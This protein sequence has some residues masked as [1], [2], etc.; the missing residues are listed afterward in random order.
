MTTAIAL[1]ISPITRAHGAVVEGVDLS[2]ELSDATIA[3]I[4][5]AVLQHKVLFFKGQSLDSDGQIRFGSLFGGLTP[6]H[7]IAGPLDPEHPQIYEVDAY[8]KDS[9]NDTWHTDIT[10]TRTPAKATILRAVKVPAIG[11]DTLFTDLEAAYDS[12]AA[13]VQGLVDQLTAVHDGSKSFAEHV[14]ANIDFNIWEGEQYRLVPVRHP[15]V[16]VHP[17]TGRKS[18]FVNPEFTRSIDGVSKYESRAILDLLFTHITKPEHIVR[19]RWS[20]G[21]VGLWDNRNTAHY[22]NYDYGDFRRVMERVTLVGDEPFGPVG[23]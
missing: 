10:F 2:Q 4:W 6:S 3:E 11:G 9:R 16:R 12:L 20:D 1:K 8:A 13:P 5:Q 19:H 7:P 21:D 17:E 15:V 14:E 18:L 22:A 23:R